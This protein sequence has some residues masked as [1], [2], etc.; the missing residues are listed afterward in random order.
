MFL[1]GIKK[2]F[3]LQESFFKIVLMDDLIQN[4]DKA[5]LSVKGL[6]VAQE[7][8]TLLGPLDLEINKGELIGLIGVSGSGKSLLSKALMGINTFQSL[9]ESYY[10][11]HWQ[12][13]LLIANESNTERL[14]KL[15]GSSIFYLFQ[16]SYL[17]LSPSRKI[18]RVFK[19]FAK[20]HNV[21]FS[22]KDLLDLF[23]SLKI[24]EPEKVL[25]RYSFEVSGG[26]LQRL[27]IG[28][29]I[30]SDAD[31]IIADEPT[32]A[33]DAPLKKEILNL[34]SQKVRANQ[35]SLLLISHNLE[36]VRSYVDRCLI[37]KEGDFV[38]DGLS[39][40]LEDASQE[41]VDTLLNCSK[42]LR[43]LEKLSEN[44][45]HEEYLLKV[46]QCSVSFFRNKFFRKQ[47]DVQ[48]V[49]SVSFD[50]KKGEALGV[51]GR[52][53]SGKSSLAKALSGLLAFTS[54][55]IS[56]GGEVLA[57]GRVH[58]DI[59]LIFQ[60]PLASL[61]PQLSIRAQLEE[62]LLIGNTPK[63]RL[64]ED[65]A[66]LLKKVSLE[67]ENLNSFP[68]ELSGGQGQRAAIARALATKPKLLICDECLS[69]LDVVL[70]VELL[71]LLESLIKND[72][73]SLLFISHDLGAV[74]RLCDRV[75]YLEHGRLVELSDHNTF[76]SKPKSENL[77]AFIDAF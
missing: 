2:P 64:G 61:N 62:A 23:L 24:Q 51:V 30:L 27:M 17:S 5:L 70:K 53:G 73:L 26:Q 22:T 7:A 45:I 59:K 19:D 65:L 46:D 11:Y 49:K 6:R 55:Q 8:H 25:E 74:A 54:S 34:L 43:K 15:R 36:L 32:T 28:M 60:N 77:K 9:R 66:L 47:L 75:A 33:L 3:I 39:S 57:S 48:S 31:L 35:K 41:D 10:S 56:I 71:N 18:K 72:N 20:Q 67:A 12:G 68:R 16:D 63:D 58:K 14:K 42:S 38:Y 1:Q 21:E 50:L 76:F 29:A 69:S 40:E 52:S 44:K 37:L 4:R 13:E